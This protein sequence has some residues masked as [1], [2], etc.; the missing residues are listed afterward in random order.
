MFS[1]VLARARACRGV[2]HCPIEAQARREG[3]RRTHV[4]PRSLAL[5]S[6]VE[7]SPP[8]IIAF[9]SLG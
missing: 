4:Y 9:D 2:M 8:K 6:R 7:K 1:K 3:V 5:L